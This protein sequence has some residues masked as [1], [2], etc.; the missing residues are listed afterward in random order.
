MPRLWISMVLRRVFLLYAICGSWLCLS[1]TAEA[2]EPYAGVLSDAHGHAVENVDPQYV[3]DAMDRA[4]VDM[5]VIMRKEDDVS[6]EDILAYHRKHPT[7]IVPVIGLQT[8]GWREHRPVFV[9]RVRAK[10]ESGEYRWMGEA[11][12]RGQVNGKLVAPPDSP[13]LQELL[14]ASAR[15]RVPLTIHHNAFDPKEI[16]ALLETLARHPRAVVVWAHWCGLGNPA[17]LRPWLDQLPNL[18]CDLGWLH[19]DQS[20]FPNPIVDREGQFVPAWKE[21]IEAYPDRFLAAVNASEVVDFRRDY[22]T[23]AEKLRKAIGGLESAVARKVAT[24]NFHR[25]L[26]R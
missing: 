8:L 11:T 10:V 18:H 15:Y 24:D 17:M 14:E 7:R 1:G 9:R 25:L 16:Q 12:L 20:A 13:L 23:R 3:I 21:L 6:D 26:G 22:Q 19:Q 4:K 5:I 2:V